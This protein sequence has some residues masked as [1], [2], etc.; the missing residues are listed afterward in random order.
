MR[1]EGRVT[2]KEVR[3]LATG[4][5][6]VIPTKPNPIGENSWLSNK[7]WCTIEE[8][9]D[10]DMFIGFDDEFPNHKVEWEKLSHHPE[11]FKVDDWPGDI[12]KEF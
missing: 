4:G 7:A 1:Q 8:V 9:S 5:T 10:L 12:S 2:D 3:F 11:P 6:K